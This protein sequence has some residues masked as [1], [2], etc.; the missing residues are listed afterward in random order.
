[1]PRQLSVFILSVCFFPCSGTA[2]ST[3]SIPEPID[4]LPKPALSQNYIVKNDVVRTYGKTRLFDCVTR[5]P[6]DFIATNVNFV[7]GNHAWW[8]GA[9][10]VSTVALLP[11]DQQITDETRK[12]AEG[13]GLS[14]D[15]RYKNVLGFVRLPQNIGAGL[16]LIGNGSTT[17]LLSVGFASYGLIAK[18]YRAQATASGLVES[19]LLSGVFSQAIKRISGRESPF[20]A[21]ENGHPG[22]K[23]SPFPG[24]GAY[25]RETP[26]YDAFPSG[27]L[28]TIMSA[29]TVIVDNYP[30]AK[31]LKPVGYSLVGALC[32]QMV[33]SEV[34]WVSD[35][36]L[37]LFMGYFIG[38]T[39]SQ[40]RYKEEK[41]TAKKK[42]YK[43]DLI[44][45][46]FSG[47]N[48]LGVNI[49]F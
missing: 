40:R 9:A 25:A 33:Q 14:E 24:F 12:F 23:W 47:H 31:W 41:T 7:K 15:N 37:A 5:A 19:L 10:A 34:H 36:P 1:M 17:I 6:K 16:Y 2:Q 26:R 8:L 29:L 44:A 38:K 48:T 4:S 18:D 35:Y 30:D 3:D 22:G 43:V 39:I 49:S 11:L 45:S 46:S 21:I 42:R 27:H 13:I 28:T 32:F 20:I